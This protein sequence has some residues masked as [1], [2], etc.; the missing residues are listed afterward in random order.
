MN[1][2]ESNSRSITVCLSELEL[3]LVEQAA[4]LTGLE[5]EQY[6]RR[7]I[8]MQTELNPNFEQVI[9]LS[10]SE[11]G[12]VSAELEKEPLVNEIFEERMKQKA[13]WEN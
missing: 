13:P 1:D 11:F 10:D 5:L 6:A 3:H 12:A 2:I 4:G 9:V 8:L 7:A